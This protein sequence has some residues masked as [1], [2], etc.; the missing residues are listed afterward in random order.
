MKYINKVPGGTI[1]IP[2]LA[3][4]LINTF[5]PELLTIGGPTTALF[6]DGNS[7]IMGIFLIICGS[8]IDIK[9]AGSTLYKGGILFH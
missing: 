1:I 7:T 8:Q 6:K 9:K 4:L 5:F 2:L 3:A